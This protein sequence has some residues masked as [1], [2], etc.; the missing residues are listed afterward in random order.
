MRAR[1]FQ[2]WKLFIKLSIFI[3]RIKLIFNRFIV[4]QT[5]FVQKYNFN[6]NGSVSKH[7]VG[8]T[9]HRSGQ[10][11]PSKSFELFEGFVNR[12]EH[13]TVV[14]TAKTTVPCP[15]AP[16]SLSDDGLLFL[17]CRFNLRQPR[18]WQGLNSGNFCTLVQ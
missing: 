8:T 4:K 6:C 16:M 7:V 11:E 5:D 12:P 14:T 13:G 3:Q 1:C 9:F 2:K 15:F 18:V 17:L 10:N